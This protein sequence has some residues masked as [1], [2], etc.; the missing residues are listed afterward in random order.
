MPAVNF[1]AMLQAAVR[2]GANGNQLGPFKL[3]LRLCG[4]R[5]TLL[6]GGWWPP[7][8]QRIT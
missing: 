8:V 3:E 5:Q 6:A 2:S 7:P 1:D 4:P